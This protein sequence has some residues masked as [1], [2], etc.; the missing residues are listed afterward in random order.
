MIKQALQLIGSGKSDF[1]FALIFV[2]IGV[3]V[4]NA[5]GYENGTS[6]DSLNPVIERVANT[7]KRLEHKGIAFEGVLISDWSSNFKGG[8]NTR[9]SSFRHLLDV[10]LNFD[11]EV[12]GL[13]KGGLVSLDFQTQEGED[14]S[15]DVGDLQ[16]YSN[17]DEADFTA[18]FEFWYEQVLLDGRLRIK[19]G[20][21]DANSEFAY[22]EYGG[23][24][25]H[26]SP[27]FSPTIFILP[28]Y[29]DSA[30]SINVFV[31]P[32][33]NLYLGFG[34]YDGAAQ[35]GFPTGR[36]GFGTFI[37]SPADLFLIG[38]VGITWELTGGLPG[39]LGV[40]VWHHTGRID[41]FDGGDRHGTTGFFLVFDQLIWKKER[42]NEK[43]GRGIGLFFQYGYS[44]KEVSEVVHHVGVGIQW[45][46][47][48]EGRNEDVSGV[49][50]SY[51]RLSE[52][53]R[54]D[55][56]MGFVS[57]HETAVEV[58]YKI[59]LGENLS[60]KPDIQYIVNPG[61]SG[62]GDAVVGTLRIEISF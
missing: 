37:E 16:A 51:A 36:R 15:E 33:E 10:R 57:D 21:V 48:I 1:V 39:R 7:R 44:D 61:G 31:H 34:L 53:F 6:V 54:D 35:E 30:L 46:G 9:G 17:I 29:P 59:Q 49:M 8:V 47:M 25:I 45:V 5:S 14:G 43:D 60:I 2:C 23:E 22:V 28:T 32:S 38:E 13:L 19:I 58:F 56:D 27:G 42:G 4:S 11:L 40:G 20:K 50:V 52:E 3:L 18:L 41:E 12:M 62:V 26:S 24:F 55:D